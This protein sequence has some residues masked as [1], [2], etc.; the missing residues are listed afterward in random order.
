M[1]DKRNDGNH[2]GVGEPLRFRGATQCDAH[3]CAPLVFASGVREFSYFLGETPDRCV[4]FLRSAFVSGVGRFSWK[5]HRLAVAADGSIHAILA[6]HDGRMIAFDDLHLVWMLLRFFGL[7][8]TIRILFRGLVL[9]RELPPPKRNQVLIAHC[10]TDERVRGTGVFSAL[11]DDAWSN[12]VLAAV[13][14]QDVMLDV[15]VSNMRARALYERLGFVEVPRP[16]SRSRRLPV[17]LASVRM[18]WIR[19]SQADA[20]Q[21]SE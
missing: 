19:R 14:G 7:L 2:T 3:A 11:F 4:A 17:D 18:R 13:D 21:V 10:A 5:R 15:L 6:V 16:R 9:E 20:E 8:R 1:L 12:G